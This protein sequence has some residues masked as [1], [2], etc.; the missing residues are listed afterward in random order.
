VI[1]STPLKLLCSW[2]T[3]ITSST[4]FITATR[5]SMLSVSRIVF[6]RYLVKLVVWRTILRRLGLRLSLSSLVQARSTS[7]EGFTAL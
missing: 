5:S 2:S 3:I 4:L 1:A 6:S 7:S